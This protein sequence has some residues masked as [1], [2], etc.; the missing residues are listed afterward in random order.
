[1]DGSLS[2]TAQSPKCANAT[3]Y[4]R[5][6]KADSDADDMYMTAFDLDPNNGNMLY[7]GSCLKIS[8]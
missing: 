5:L 8:T 7:G 4:P 2:E 1:M 3:E 6:I